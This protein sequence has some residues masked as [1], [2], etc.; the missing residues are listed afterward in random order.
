MLEI[1][2]ADLDT[3][4]LHAL[5]LTVPGTY[6]AISQE[7]GRR[8]AYPELDTGFTE[9]ALAVAKFENFLA[10]TKHTKSV[11]SIVATGLLTVSKRLLATARN[12]DFNVREPNLSQLV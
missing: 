6:A 11:K 8:N 1:N 2:L 3:D 9:L 12:E 5:A 4:A 10:T 7:L